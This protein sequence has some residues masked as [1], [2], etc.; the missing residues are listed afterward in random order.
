MYSIPVASNAND[1]GS[2][3]VSSL[4]TTMA[5]IAPKRSDVASTP[6]STP[7]GVAEENPHARAQRLSVAF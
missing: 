2:S 3:L 4:A 7:P 5:P 6:E 1:V